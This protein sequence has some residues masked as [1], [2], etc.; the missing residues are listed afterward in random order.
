MDGEG[1]LPVKRYRV[2]P[3]DKVDLR[4]IDP[5]DI[6]AEPGA[7]DEARAELEKL[8]RKLEELQEL[9]YAQHEHKLLIVLQGMDTSG[10]DGTIR[11][12]FE[13]VNPQGVDVTSFKEPSTIEL[14]HDYLWRVHKEVPPKGMIRIFN[15]SHYE[16]VLV[17]RVHG[18]ITAE[19][20]ERRYR[21]INEFERMLVDEDTT[22]LKF[23]LHIS[24][25][26]Q[27]RRLQARLSDPHKHWKFSES[28]VKERTR[29]DDYWRAYERCFMETSTERAPWYV[30][31]SNKKWYRNLAVARLI[32]GALEDMKMDYPTCKIDLSK[33][34]ID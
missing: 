32:V 24:K 19:E 25:D 5:D 22:I 3:G 20:C 2:K 18:L 16:D 31:P 29:W 6:S 30:I 10:K 17:V 14:A 21:H 15:R 33:I 28:D 9:L 34:H 12:V 23:F 7:K 4:K 27:K 11:H 26:E 1:G 13:G 8:N